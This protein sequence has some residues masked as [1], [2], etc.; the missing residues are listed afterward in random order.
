MKAKPIDT[1]PAETAAERVTRLR[2]ELESVKAR[3]AEMRQAR[4]RGEAVDPLTLTELREEAEALVDRIAAAEDARARGDAA[5]AARREAEEARA[6]LT[7][8]AALLDTTEAHCEA[9]RAAAE[10][11]AA[12]M[13]ALHEH[14][15]AVGRTEASL[16]ARW[17]SGVTERARTQIAAAWPAHLSLELAR[18][19]PFR[20]AAKRA[21]WPKQERDTLALLLGPLPADPD[22]AAAPDAA[23]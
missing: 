2:G 3:I 10:S 22:A 23:A 17:I 5:E 8:V 19:I 9:V 6:R 4:G 1:T 14:V 18:P 15:A 7:S 13:A 16:G 12:A 20:D 21:A 11:L